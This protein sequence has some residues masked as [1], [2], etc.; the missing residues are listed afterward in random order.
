MLW[1]F[2]VSLDKQFQVS[3]VIGSAFILDTLL[4]ILDLVKKAASIIHDLDNLQRL[5]AL[6]GLHTVA[7][8]HGDDPNAIDQGIWEDQWWNYLELAT[9]PA[10][11]VCP[12]LPL[13]QLG[14]Y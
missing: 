8:S 3:S 12:F 10:N 5:N 9:F 4:A 13:C 14:A 11:T 2:P 7:F 1:M 6:D